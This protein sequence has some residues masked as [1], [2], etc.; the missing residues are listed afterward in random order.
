[1]TRFKKKQVKKKI[2]VNLVTL[3]NLLPWAQN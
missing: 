2:E 3:V 1:M